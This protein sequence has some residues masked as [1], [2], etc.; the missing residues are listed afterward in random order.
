MSSVVNIRKAI[1]KKEGYTD[2]EDW[3][4]NTDHVYIGRNMCFYVSGNPTGCVGTISN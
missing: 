3:A 1:L 2:F 4:K